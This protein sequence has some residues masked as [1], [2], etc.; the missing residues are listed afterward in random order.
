MGCTISTDG[1]EPNSN[2]KNKIVGTSV[3]YKPLT[4]QDQ[5]R[6]DMIFDY[7]YDEDEWSDTKY[8][9]FRTLLE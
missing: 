3:E 9:Q 8:Q 4:K 5:L 2:K 7:W 1:T 6:I